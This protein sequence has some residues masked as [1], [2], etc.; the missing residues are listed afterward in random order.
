MRNRIAHSSFN[1]ILSFLFKVS[2]L[3]ACQIPASMMDFA[4][5]IKQMRMVTYV[6]ANEAL[7]ET[8]AR[9]RRFPFFKNTVI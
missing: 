8:N 9:V 7:L 5:K 3:L 2:V 4:L 6:F 1:K